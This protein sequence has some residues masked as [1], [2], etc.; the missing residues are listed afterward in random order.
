MADFI[1][2]PKMSE[3][4]RDVKCNIN[5]QVLWKIIL[6]EKLHF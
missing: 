4:M 2:S 1:P 3:I 5:L 6:Q